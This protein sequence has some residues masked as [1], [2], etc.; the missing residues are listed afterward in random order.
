MF[1]SEVEE[2]PLSIEKNGLRQKIFSRKWGHG[3][4]RVELRGRRWK[5]GVK[6]IPRLEEVVSVRE[7]KKREN[8]E[9][10]N[11]EREDCKKG[12]GGRIGGVLKGKAKTRGKELENKGG[13]TGE[14]KGDGKGGRK[15]LITVTW[16]V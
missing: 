15:G 1:F 2:N 6:G 8:S 11:R 7:E 3:G 12:D 9:V 13:R 14:K 10:E 5:G 4:A 16:V